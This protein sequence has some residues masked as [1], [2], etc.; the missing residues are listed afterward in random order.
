MGEIL[1]QECGTGNRRLVLNMPGRCYNNRVMMCLIK[2]LNHF[3]ARRWTITIRNMYKANV[4]ACRNDLF[5]MFSK[6]DL[7]VD[8]VPQLFEGNIPDYSYMMWIDS[9][10]LWEPLDIERLMSWNMDIV[11]GVAKMQDGKTIATVENWD[12]AYYKEHGSFKYLNDE[13]IKDRTEPFPVAFTGMAFMLIRRG[14]LE[15]FD[16]PWIEPYFYEL[17]KTKLMAGEDVSFCKKAQNLGFKVMLDP[18][19]RIGH[20]KEVTIR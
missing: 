12:L 14:V 11:C 2:T 7:K 20:L 6:E 17:G 16:F 13:L 5:G 3:R 18:K 4:W 9:D 19:T 15:T 10:M 1:S 8:R